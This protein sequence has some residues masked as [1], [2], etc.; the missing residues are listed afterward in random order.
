MD[1][2]NKTKSQNQT[3]YSSQIGTYYIQPLQNSDNINNKKEITINNYNNRS[4]L[5]Q[6]FLDT[7]L[8]NISINFGFP[9]TLNSYD[10]QNSYDLIENPVFEQRNFFYYDKNFNLFKN[11]S[12][13][14]YGDKKSK[15]KSLNKKD[16]KDRVFSPQHKIITSIKKKKYLEENDT[17][18]KRPK[19]PK[20]ETDIYE[21]E[22]INQVLLNDDS[23]G[24][25][26]KS[27]KETASSKSAKE[28]EGEWGEI[29]QA[30]FEEKKLKDNLLNS[31]CIEIEKDNGDKQVKYLEISKDENCLNEDPCLK[32]KYTLEDKICLNCTPIKH[33]TVKPSSKYSSKKKSDIYNQYGSNI[34]P[35]KKEN[36]SEIHLKE[37]K[38]SQ[39]M[40]SFSET[41]ERTFFSGSTVPSTQKY[42]KYSNAMNNLN[43][44]KIKDIKPINHRFNEEKE[45]KSTEVNKSNYLTRKILDKERNLSPN[46]IMNLKYNRS[47]YDINANK[48]RNYAIENKEQIKEYVPKRDIST[49]KETKK[50]KSLS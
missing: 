35:Y 6:K 24:K 40:M 13:S 47:S 2:K 22:V 27:G 18:D 48:K 25:S 36:V 5:K 46:K 17:E 29:E 32:I 38:S 49:Q 45:E 11:K 44:K 8:K 4:V 12:V 37:S 7:Q 20:K 31:V 33:P 28:S 10:Y 16:Y 15:E 3:H 42:L 26:K 21:L 19:A 14:R 41:N 34:T 39:N 23:E 30:I 1:S 43:E 9:N 50:I